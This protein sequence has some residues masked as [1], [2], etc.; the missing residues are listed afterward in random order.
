MKRIEISS[1][2]KEAIEQQAFG[3]IIAVALSATSMLI[4]LGI[5]VATEAKE[6]QSSQSKDQN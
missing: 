4:M 1:A 6:A 2:Q 3:Q 5:K